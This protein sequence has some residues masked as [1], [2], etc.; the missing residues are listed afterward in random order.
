M[1][2]GA[3]L[4]PYNIDGI[5]DKE[6][7]IIVEGEA[8]TL[9]FI[10]AGITNVISVPNGANK[11]LEWLDEF[12]EG[13]FEDKQNI[14]VA[15]DN[16]DKGLQ[17]RDELVRRFGAERCMIV[18]WS[19]GCKDANDELKKN[20]ADGLRAKFNGAK[21]VK[22]GGVF[23]LDDYADE[24]DRIYRGG[25]LQ[26]GMT[27]GHENFDDLISFETK[28]LCIVTGEPSSGKSEFI[29]EMCVRLNLRYG[30]KTG[31]FSPENMPLAYHAVKL[32]EKVAGTKLTRMGE[33]MYARTKAFIA[34]NFF[35]IM[36]E[37]G[38]SVEN[39]LEK[40]QYLVR[41]KGI[42]ILVIDPF[43]RLDLNYGRES[44]T[45][46]ISKILDALTNFAQRND[47]LVC[48]MAHPRKIN[49]T[50]NTEGVPTLSDINGSKNFWNK[51]D[52]G[53]VV[54]RYKEQGYTLVRVSK[55]KFRHLGQGGDAKFKYNVENGRY[56]PFAEGHPVVFDNSDYL[57]PQGEKNIPENNYDFIN[58]GENECP[59]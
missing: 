50:E 44:E 17:L 16:D 35:H 31:F 23:S 26:P 42:K 20:G 46:C 25:G 58:K 41:R 9:S 14:Y 19:Q 56:S 7:A 32:M 52:Y 47:V 36:P 8:D 59:F 49:R 2:A 33:E 15:V 55:V 51:A 34:E 10:E 43:N 24:L 53:I 28:R 6:T 57:A 12:W 40:A 1:C 30:L 27:I 13:W 38:Y 11:N 5:K 4:I 29:D 48:L 39:I 21:E 3:E 45:N 37:D 54:H 18:E 22:I